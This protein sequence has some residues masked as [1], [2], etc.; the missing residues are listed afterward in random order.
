M[1]AQP[2]KTRILR[3][4]VL[5]ALLVGTSRQPID[6]S[7]VLDGVFLS[8]DSKSG[9]A[10]SALKALALTGQALRF[11]RPAPPSSYAAIQPADHSRSAV[12]EALRPMLVRMFGDRAGIPAGDTLELA[13]ALA[14]EARRLQ[15]HP[16]D[17][18]R[19]E[20]FLRA[21]AER[22]GPDACAWVDREKSGQKTDQ[23][24]R[25]FFDIA[26]LDDGNWH[27]ATP[28]RRKR[29]IQDRRQQDADASRALVEAV[30]PNEAA[31]LRFT[32][33]Q[34]LRTGLC[35]ADTPFLESLAK[36]RAPRVRQL[37]ERYLSR[38]SGPG[39]QNPALTSLIARIVKGEA[40]WLRKRPTLTLELPAT[41]TGEGW[42][43]WVAESFESVE[44]DEFAGALGLRP[45]DMIAA[46]AQDRCLST[47]V[48][49]MAFRQGDAAI[50]GQAYAALPETAPWLEEQLLQSIEEVE[51]DAR[52]ELAEF[53]LRKSFAAGNITSAAL[54]QVHRLLHGPLSDGL[55]DEIMRAPA[56]PAWSAPDSGDGA[57][58]APLAAL[59]SSAKRSALRAALA[60][61]DSAPAMRSVQF[62]DILDSLER[63]SPRE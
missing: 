34:A 40:G 36:D 57:L 12:P 1:S 54:A 51:P 2:S 55:I 45:S 63:V 49:I 17:F 43:G 11:A 32:L 35:S 22:L 42:R 3:T 24:K 19:M 62:L 31:D 27:E 6:V 13:M 21:H 4:R 33:L 37:A 60:G 53:L 20:G 16:F 8:G 18:P 14:L 44:L 38:L 61:I 56:W 41:V 48:A 28:A 5:P 46:A 50:A 58:F 15:P 30:W 7:R 47:A 25:G 39:A 23:E 26:V 9:D 10:K 29:Y 59:C 52:K